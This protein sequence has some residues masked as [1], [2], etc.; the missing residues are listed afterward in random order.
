MD[1]HGEAMQLYMLYSVASSEDVYHY[2]WLNVKR[3]HISFARAA[4]ISLPY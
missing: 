2:G 3:E 4:E 1:E